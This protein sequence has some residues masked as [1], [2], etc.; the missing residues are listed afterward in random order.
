LLLGFSALFAI[1][2]PPVGPVGLVCFVA[3]AVLIERVRARGA[4]APSPAA[5]AGV[6]SAKTAI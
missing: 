4:T 2:P 5:A 6:G 1:H 3:A